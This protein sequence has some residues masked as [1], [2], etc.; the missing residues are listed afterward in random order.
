[1][2]LTQEIVRE[3]LDYDPETGELRWKER[4]A[5]WFKS[6]GSFRAW[7]SKHAGRRA[8]TSIQ[9]DGYRSGRVFSQSYLAHRLIWFWMVGRWP[10]AV[11]HI[12]GDAANNRWSNLRD[13]PQSTNAKNMKRSAKNKSGVTGVCWHKA[14]NR[15][16][17]KI[18]KGYRIHHLGIF[19]DF[20][21]AVKVRKE[22]EREYGFHPNHGRS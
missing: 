10:E 17:A 4:D 6:Q 3:L 2:E 15:W 12:D 16:I 8:F 14:S 7:N 22:A 18:T 9:K 11:D 13:V 5:K 21:E 20:D 19:K 1:M